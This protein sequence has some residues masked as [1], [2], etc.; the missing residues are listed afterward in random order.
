MG[1]TTIMAVVRPYISANSCVRTGVAP[2]WKG[3]NFLHTFHDIHL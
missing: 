2:G 1:V 3:L